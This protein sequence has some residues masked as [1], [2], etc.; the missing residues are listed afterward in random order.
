MIR[1]FHCLVAGFLLFV[2]AYCHADPADGLVGRWELLG[3]CRDAR[4]GN[5]AIN[6]GVDLTPDGAVFDGRRA[7]L[8]VPDTTQVYS[9]AVY[10]GRLY[11]ANWPTGSVLV[12]GVED[13]Q[14]THVGRLGEEREVMGVAVYNGKLYAG[15]LPLGQVYRFESPGNW[16]L[17]GQLDDTPDATYRRVW[18]MAIYGG[19]SARL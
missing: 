10:E 5:N 13:N 15:T 11:L 2:S 14:W 3:D 16:A 6:H 7:W 4:G 12:Y 18:S 17:T 9:F 8:E 19:Q 1:T